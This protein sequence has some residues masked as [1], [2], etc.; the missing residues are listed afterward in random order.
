MKLAVVRTA[1]P[2]FYS[3]AK[4][5]YFPVATSGVETLCLKSSRPIPFD[6]SYAAPCDIGMLYLT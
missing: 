5:S 4:A 2:A 6:V 3:A 1:F